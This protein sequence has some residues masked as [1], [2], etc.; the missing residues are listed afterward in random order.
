MV[1]RFFRPSKLREQ[2]NPRSQLSI[3]KSATPPTHLRR[4][5]SS[6]EKSQ[7]ASTIRQE[8]G[9]PGRADSV[10]ATKV[11]VSPLFYLLE[12]F[13]LRQKPLGV[14]FTGPSRLEVTFGH[15]V[16]SGLVTT[17]GFAQC[18][19]EDADVS[20]YASYFGWGKSLIAQFPF[21]Q[22]FPPPLRSWLAFV[23]LAAHVQ[24]YLDNPTD[25]PD[26]PGAGVPARHPYPPKPSLRVIG[27]EAP[28]ENGDR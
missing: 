1:P 18:H 9:E 26:P 21:Q 2:Q 23:R 13:Y 11:I 12:S 6:P 24:R 8:I 10:I 22:D 16:S 14:R 5:Y 7:G 15:F 19:L 25:F 20:V 4:G 17:E 3:G 28:L 27:G